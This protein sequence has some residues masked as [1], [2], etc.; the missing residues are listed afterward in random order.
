LQLEKPECGALTRNILE[1][2]SIAAALGEIGE[3]WSL[4]II[5]EAL[6]GSARFD[7]FHENL[8]VARNILSDRL[9]TLTRH[10][11][12]LKTPSPANARIFHYRLTKKGREIL[13][14]LAALMHWGDAWI[15]EGAGAPI[16]LVDRKTRTPIRKVFLE[17]EDGSVLEPSDIDILAGPGATDFMR[18]RLSAHAASKDGKRGSPPEKFAAP[19]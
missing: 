16:V 12:L 3:R 19:E 2:C 15:N 11:V 7:E 13:P 4:L 18:V 9:S 6:M 8:G 1:N 14:V 5:R 10:G 17:A